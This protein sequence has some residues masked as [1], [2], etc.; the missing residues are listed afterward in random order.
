MFLFFYN[1]C[2]PSE[3]GYRYVLCDFNIPQRRPFSERP[4]EPS[5]A[6]YHGPSWLEGSKNLCVDRNLNQTRKAGEVRGC[7]ARVRLDIKAV[8]KWIS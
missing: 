6:G 3:P 5:H 4:R 1:K 2:Q 7:G 8:E